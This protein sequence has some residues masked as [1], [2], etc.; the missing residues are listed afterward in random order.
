MKFIEPA[1]KTSIVPEKAFQVNDG[2][3]LPRLTRLISPA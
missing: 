1:F 3:E 2:G